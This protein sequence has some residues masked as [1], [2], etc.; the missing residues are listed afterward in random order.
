[1]KREELTERWK[2]K[3]EGAKGV[4][5]KG[6]RREGVDGLASK[7]EGVTVEQLLLRSEAFRPTLSDLKSRSRPFPRLRRC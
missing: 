6:I 4:Q 2:E 5:E 7:L 3:R 1:M